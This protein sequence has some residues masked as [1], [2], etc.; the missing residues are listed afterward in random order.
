MKK[1]ILSTVL[2]FVLLLSFVPTVAHAMSFPDVDNNSPY[3]TA[4]EY[5]S[6][7]GIMVGDSN[8]NFNPNGIVNRA[9][10]ATIVCRVL[11]QTENLS[12]SNVFTDVPVNHW[13]NAYIAKASQLGIVG[14]YGGGKFGPGDPV[15]FE[16]AVTMV[17]R[18]INEEA[19]AV[20]Y[21]G[22]PN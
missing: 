15:T 3:S 6:T 17:V 20:A 2:S 5:V 14:G 22:Y 4:I 11:G 19:T 1:R 13:A 21:G 8:G 9:E 7:I 18:S 12:K 16:Q 10:M